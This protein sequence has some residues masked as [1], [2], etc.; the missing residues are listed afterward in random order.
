VAHTI[1]GNDD[2][3]LEATNALNP[4]LAKN[5][6]CCTGIY[7]GQEYIRSDSKFCRETSSILI[8]VHRM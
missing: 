5:Y 1:I 3:A 7:S 4:E 8:E 6:C 2:D